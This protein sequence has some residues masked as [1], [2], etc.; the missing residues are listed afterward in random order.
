M[1][2]AGE[3]ER[4]PA[5]SQR[6]GIVN[7]EAHADEAILCDEHELALLNLAP[8]NGSRITPHRQLSGTFLGRSDSIG[9]PTTSP[10]FLSADEVLVDDLSHRQPTGG[11][12]AG[13]TALQASSHI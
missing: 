12:L 2:I 9:K 5:P 11:G 8:A 7:L 13:P 4:A 6:I 1:A 10:V 3:V